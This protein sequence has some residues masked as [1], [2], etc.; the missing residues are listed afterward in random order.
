VCAAHSRAEKQQAA[1]RK[2]IKD[3]FASDAAIEFQTAPDLVGGIELIAGGQKLG[4]SIAD[5]LR[6]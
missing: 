5:Y 6:Q 2:T 3:V 1:I 4:L